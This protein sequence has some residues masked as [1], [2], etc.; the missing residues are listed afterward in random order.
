MGLSPLSKFKGQ[1][2]KRN[3]KPS[4]EQDTAS[5]V[6]ILTWNSVGIE[7]DGLS[8]IVSGYIVN[9]NCYAAVESDC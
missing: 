2:F 1:R 3:I 4:T 7:S 5:L 9:K 6:N 8:L